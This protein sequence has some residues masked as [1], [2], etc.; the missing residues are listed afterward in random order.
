VL[1]CE[2]VEF[3]YPVDMETDIVERITVKRND[4]GRCELKFSYLQNI[5]RLGNEFTQPKAQTDRQARQE[6]PG[7]M[8]LAVLAGNRQ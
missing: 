1:K 3:A 8:W 7:M 4:G 5:D 6:P 2:Q